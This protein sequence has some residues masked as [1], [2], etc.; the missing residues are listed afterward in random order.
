MS[1]EEI[2]YWIVHNIAVHH[3]AM[4]RGAVP[5]FEAAWSY[6]QCRALVR[7][8]KLEPMWRVPDLIEE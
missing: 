6:E 3:S 8:T 7:R 5:K 4:I 2:T 1:S